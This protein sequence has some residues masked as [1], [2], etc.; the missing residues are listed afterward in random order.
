[1]I[2]KG[3]F[4][5]SNAVSHV[6]TRSENAVLV[7]DDVPNDAD[8]SESVVEENNFEVEE[9]EEEE[10][11]YVNPKTSVTIAFKHS[12]L[13]AIVHL[14]IYFTNKKRPFANSTVSMI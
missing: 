2:S 9:D 8:D 10:G 4:P 7:E 13:I 3:D 6:P 14:I 11:E 12:Q 1:V 5:S